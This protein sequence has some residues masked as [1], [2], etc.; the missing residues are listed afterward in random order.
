MSERSEAFWAIQGR[1]QRGTPFLY[2]GTWHTRADAIA[3]HTAE[4]GCDWNSCRKNGDRA[5][6][7]E[8]SYH[9]I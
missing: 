9:A 8:V 6:R 7:V 2:C 3:A 4:K 5:V 1:W